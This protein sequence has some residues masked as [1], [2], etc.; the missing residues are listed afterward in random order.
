[1]QDPILNE[2]WKGRKK[3]RIKKILNK[4]IQRVLKR[5]GNCLQKRP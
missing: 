1:M 3:N 4:V 5:F 2:T